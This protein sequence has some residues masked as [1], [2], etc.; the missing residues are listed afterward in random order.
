MTFIVKNYIINIGIFSLLN[1][2]FTIYTKQ[3]KCNNQ[4]NLNLTNGKIIWKTIRIL[5]KSC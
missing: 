2:N 5:F 3:Q 1:S 4:N